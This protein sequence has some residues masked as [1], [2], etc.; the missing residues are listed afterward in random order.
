MERLTIKQGDALA[1]LKTLPDESIHCCVTSPPYFGLRDYGVVGQIGLEDSIEDYLERIVAVFREVRRVLRSD[2]TL[3]LNIG[4]SYANDTKWGGKS[5]KLNQTS[6]AGG[7]GG[8]RLKR[9]TGLKPKDLMMMPARVAMALQE[10][11]WFLRAD[12][13]WHKT[14]PMPESVHDRPTRAHE[15]LFLLTRSSRYFYDAEAIR[16]Q[17]RPNASVATATGEVI[18]RRN[19]RSVWSLPVHGYQESHFATYRKRQ[20]KPRISMRGMNLPLREAGRL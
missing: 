11:G 18:Q 3:W 20:R 2:G 9:V 16:E 10:D 5:G 19:K 7:Y 13:I 1:V 4:D 17:V 14:N 6:A 8:Q 12:I 15:Y